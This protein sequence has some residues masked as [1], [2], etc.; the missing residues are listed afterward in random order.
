V[1]PT[2]QSLTV[3]GKFTTQY[4]EPSSAAFLYSD[5]VGNCEPFDICFGTAGQPNTGTWS[6]EMNASVDFGALNLALNAGQGFRVGVFAADADGTDV[7]RNTG[8]GYGAFD[9]T[10]RIKFSEIAEQTQRAVVGFGITHGPPDTTAEQKRMLQNGAAFVCYGGT[11][12]WIATFAN[13]NTLD[14]VDSGVAVGAY[15]TLR[16]ITNT[17]GTLINFYIDGNLI[18][19]GA[20]TFDPASTLGTWGAEARDKKTG[21]STNAVSLILDYMAL[22]YTLSR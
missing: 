6:Y 9:F 2:V 12:N 18:R 13:N 1:T 20:P 4:P 15:H 16:I 14:E 11:G 17:A 5:F 7:D 22:K 19:S 21:G 10:A 3:A 8:L